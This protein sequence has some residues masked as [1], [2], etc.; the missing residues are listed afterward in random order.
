MNTAT[1]T[2]WAVSNFVA[3]RDCQNARYHEPEKQVPIGLLQS[4][5]T[6]VL[7]KWLS[8]FVAET[9]KQDG[10][11][12]PPKSVY[13]LLTGLLRH[14]RTLSPLSPNF[15][16]TGDRQFSSF[17]NALDNA[18][19]ELRL[20]GVGFETK[21]AQSFTKEEEESLWESGV[22]STTNAKGWL[23]AVFFLNGKNF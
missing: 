1:S 12:Y 13:M 8:L 15:L 23:R 10:S 2:K 21:E 5:N 16:G 19:R 3:W 17:H 4:N 11:R 7:S 6:A 18:L 14:M 22:L 9:G 20:Q